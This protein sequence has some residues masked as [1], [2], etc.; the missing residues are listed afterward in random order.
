VNL[1]SGHPAVFSA[2][3]SH[4]VWA[5]EGKAALLYYRDKFTVPYIQLCSSCVSPPP[6]REAHLPAHYALE[7]GGQ[8]TFS[9]IMILN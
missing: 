7:W 4:G 5:Q 8:R 6:P 9:F 2:N 1:E 3:G